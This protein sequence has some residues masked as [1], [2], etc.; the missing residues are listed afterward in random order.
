MRTSS[1]TVSV[2]RRVLVT[3]GAGFIGSRVVA[4]L[5]H[6]GHDV[7]VA[8]S[9]PPADPEIEHVSGD[10]LDPAVREKAFASGV[11]AVV[12]L[13]AFTSVLKSVERPDECLRHNVELTA[14]RL[15]L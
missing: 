6:T 2:G 12:H 10:L 8:D 13:A 11:D 3:G 9:R 14:A 7:V 5:R 15:E 4:G 1:T